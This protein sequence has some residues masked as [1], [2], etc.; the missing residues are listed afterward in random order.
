MIKLFLKP[1]GIKGLKPFELDCPASA[2]G[3]SV[4]DLV[5]ARADVPVSLICLGKT[6]D[7]A[8]SLLDQQ[9]SEG[10]KIVVS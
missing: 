2:T 6:I 1:V 5:Q 7:P 8:L 10:A 4:I 9:V 3:Q